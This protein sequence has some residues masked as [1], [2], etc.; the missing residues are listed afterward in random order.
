MMYELTFAIINI[1]R[2]IHS[3]EVSKK[4]F[5]KKKERVKY[6]QELDTSYKSFVYK[7]LL[8]HFI[9]FV[10]FLQTVFFECQNYENF[11]DRRDF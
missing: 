8:L 10:F 2:K 5:F 11:F 6:I 1:K 9:S 7:I 3:R 4:I